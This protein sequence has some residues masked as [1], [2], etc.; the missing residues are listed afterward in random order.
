[1][2]TIISIM[3]IGIGIGYLMRNVQMLQK[4]EKSASLTILLLLFVLGVSIGSNRLIVDNLGRF[5]WQAA[6]LASL[7]IT[8]SML[9]SLSITGSML[10]SLMVFHIFFKKGEKR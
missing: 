1:M 4:V 9:A 8:G 3:F 10:A 2:F 6:V 5:G 7:S